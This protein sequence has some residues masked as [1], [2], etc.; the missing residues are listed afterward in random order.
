MSQPIDEVRVSRDGAL[1]EIVMNRPKTKNALS[2]AMYAAMKAALD[3]AAADDSVLL[4]LFRGEG[5]NFTSGNDLK[6]FLENPPKGPESTVFQF[7]STIA[8]FP[9]PVI[10]AVDGVAIGLGTTMLFHCDLVYAAENTRF[11]M[12]FT[13]LALV[14]EAASS[15]ILPRMLGHRR[16]AEV[17]YFGEMFD[18][19]VA[20]ELGLVNQAVPADQVLSVARA[21]AAK[22]LEKSPTAIR[23]TKELLRTHQWA[24]M[25]EHMDLEAT[26]FASLLGTPE[27]NEAISAFFEKRKPDF[28]KLRQG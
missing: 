16:A 28:A 8:A 24:A 7:I 10:A 12:P 15:F 21:Q 18:V 5:G 17:L 14:P 13:S 11:S 26:T 4:V 20:R 1:L 6:D 25:K 19:S 22:L 23:K 2:V 9:K 27:V 3:E